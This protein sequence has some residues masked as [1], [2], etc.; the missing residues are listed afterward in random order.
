MVLPRDRLVGVTHTLPECHDVGALT[1]VCR[2]CDTRHF[3]GKR[4]TTGHF[5][6]CCNNGQVITTGD[7]VLFPAPYL[8]MNLLTSDSQDSRRYRADIRRYNNTGI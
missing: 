3:P 7:R 5:S 1:A 2:H 8:L 6:T 4:T